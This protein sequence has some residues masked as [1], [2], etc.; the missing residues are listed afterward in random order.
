MEASP[1]P[2]IGRRVLVVED[3]GLIAMQLEFDLQEVG[4][5]VVG[6][7]PAVRQALRLIERE[8]VD[9]A[10]LDYQLRGET[11][12]VIADALIARNIPFLLLT[13]HALND[14]PGELQDQ[15]CLAKPAD[16]EVLIAALEAIVTTA[17]N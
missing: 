8:A 17:A 3:E 9:V 14:L 16:C 5:E 2:L 13:G 11:S 6:P 4:C 15:L 10:V 1:S 7:A 12:R